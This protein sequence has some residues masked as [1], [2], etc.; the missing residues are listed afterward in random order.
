MGIVFCGLVGFCF[1]YFF[2]SFAP[3]WNFLVY[4]CIPV[5]P[6]GFSLIEYIC[7]THQ[8][9]NEGYGSQHLNDYHMMIARTD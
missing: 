3:W 5:G 1:A 6:F 8:K 4:H 7:F 9:N 2:S